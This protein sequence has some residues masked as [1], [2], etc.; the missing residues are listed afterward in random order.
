MGDV[1]MALTYQQNSA[2][3]LL[4]HLDENNFVQQFSQGAAD[5]SGLVV[6]GIYCLFRPSFL[7]INFPHAF[8]FE[9]K[10][11]QEQLT[12]RDLLGMISEGYYLDIS[13]PHAIEKA[14]KDFPIIFASTPQ[15]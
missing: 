2:H 8:S 15:T 14:T 6:G 7:N 3:D 13:K 4:A 11:L 9:E 10:Y 5:K 12:D 1:T